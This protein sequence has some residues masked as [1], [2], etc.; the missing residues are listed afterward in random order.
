MS[1]VYAGLYGGTILRMSEERDEE[2]QS[3]EEGNDVIMYIVYRVSFIA[4]SSRQTMN[5]K[6]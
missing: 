2:E 6:R 4:A 5:N 1:S 3:G